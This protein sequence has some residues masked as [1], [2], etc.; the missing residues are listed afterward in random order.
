MTLKNALLTA[1]FVVV[2]LV[3]MLATTA[4][5]VLSLFSA[6]GGQLNYLWITIVAFL[7][8]IIE[9]AFFLYMAFKN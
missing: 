6:I 4:V 3:V 7:A 8:F 9:F 2:M 5:A 1:G